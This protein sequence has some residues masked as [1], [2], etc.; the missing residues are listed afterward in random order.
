[1]AE[2]INNE[3]RELALDDLFSGL[4]GTI[5]ESIRTPFGIFDNNF[6]IL[7]IN[8]ALARIHSCNAESVI[9]DICYRAFHGC[10]KVCENCFLEEVRTM[11]R[12][13]V[14]ERSHEF[15]DGKTRWG[16]LHAYPV[17]GKD[18][19]VAAV[20]VIIFETTS[21]MDSL[22]R[23]KQYTSLLVDKLQARE[24]TGKSIP[25][26]DPSGGMIQ[27]LSKREKEILGL[28]VDG[29][30]NPQISA[31]LSISGNTVKRHTSN[32]FLK[33]NVNDRTQAAV[34]AVRENLI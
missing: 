22:A 33:L 12:T 3:G 19:S 34:L 30:T 18:R 5:L 23:H 27:P 28:I 10:D 8:K 14:L 24:D 17:R 16:E 29:Y 9:G 4:G 25:K 20:V 26:T 21:R 2:E 1:M 32:L 13:V 6:R 7:W 31:M 11:G 15:P